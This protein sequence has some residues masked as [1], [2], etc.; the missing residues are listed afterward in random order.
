MAVAPLSHTEVEERL[1]ALPGWRVDGDHLTR[2]YAFP[3]HP[4][5]AA[6]VVHVAQVQEE[7]N[8]HADLLLSYD[9]LTVTVNTHSVGG[10]ITELDLTLAGRLAE[11][12]PGHGAR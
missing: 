12:A 8:H 7:L 2:T 5:A 10:K 4:Q 1:S 3:G 11:I 6:M 9:R